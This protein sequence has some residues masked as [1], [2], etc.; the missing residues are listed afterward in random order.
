MRKRE[1]GDGWTIVTFTLPPGADGAV[2]TVHGDFN[3]WHGEDHVMLATDGGPPE[4]SLRLPPGR[5]EF[6]YCLDGD[7]WINDPD[8]D[9]FSPNPFGGQNSVVYTAP[10][11]DASL[12]G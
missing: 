5:F 8:A 4:L 7:V 1:G 3:D 12:A 9:D 6:R 2:V 11:G 10:A